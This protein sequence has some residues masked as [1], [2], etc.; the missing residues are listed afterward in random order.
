[1]HGDSPQDTGGSHKEDST[2]LKQEDRKHYMY[3][4]HVVDIIGS[5]NLSI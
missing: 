5:L 1:M 3:I 2:V 4:R